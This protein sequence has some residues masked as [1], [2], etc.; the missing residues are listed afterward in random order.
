MENMSMCL[1]RWGQVEKESSSMEASIFGASIQSKAV[2]AHYG[3]HL[4]Y[5]PL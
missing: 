2:K 4:C 1:A 3:A 5:N